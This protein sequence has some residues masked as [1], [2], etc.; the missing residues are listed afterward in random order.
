MPGPCSTPNGDTTIVRGH[1]DEEFMLETRLK[2]F[3]EE[4]QVW[5]PKREWLAK[6]G[7]LRTGKTDKTA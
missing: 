4:H 7:K 2:G 3:A 1:V 5:I 6:R